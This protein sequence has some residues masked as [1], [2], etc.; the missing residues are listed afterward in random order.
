MRVRLTTGA[1]VVAVLTAGVSSVAVF[2]SDAAER[3]CRAVQ[4]W[5]VWGTNP[6]PPHADNGWLGVELPPDAAEGG[7]LSGTIAY[8]N[9]HRGWKSA[10]ALPTRYVAVYCGGISVSIEDARWWRPSEGAPFLR[11]RTPG[12]VAAISC[13]SPAGPKRELASEIYR[14]AEGDP[15]DLDLDFEISIRPADDPP[16][17][18]D[19]SGESQALAFE[20]ELGKMQVAGQQRRDAESRGW[21]PV[22][23]CPETARVSVVMVHGAQDVEYA[24]MSLRWNGRPVSVEECCA[25]RGTWRI[26]GEGTRVVARSLISGSLAP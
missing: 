8:R 5:W 2:R 11:L 6:P 9:G 21:D 10:G 20:A 14:F 24:D 19:E 15:V 12:L 4:S 25:D 7:T 3:G 26:A 18:S 13:N 1:I 17:S 23:A 22:L 16:A